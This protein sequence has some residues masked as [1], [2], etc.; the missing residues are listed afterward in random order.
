MY[1]LPKHVPKAQQQLLK[2]G[3]GK[4]DA[5]CENR[6]AARCLPRPEMDSPPHPSMEPRT[7]ISLFFWPEVREFIK[8]F[9]E[10][11]LLRINQRHHSLRTRLWHT[12][13]AAV[14][15]PT[16]ENVRERGL[17]VGVGRDS[18]YGSIYVCPPPPRDPAPWCSP[19]L[20]FVQKRRVR[21][22]EEEGPPVGVLRSAAHR[23]FSLAT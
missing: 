12:P 11:S 19:R 14:K 21:G 4:W 22:G 9:C 23:G 18:R 13:P 7:I 8:D 10:S 5:R 17:G 15:K 16:E 6:D 2:F 3:S 1:L 20:S